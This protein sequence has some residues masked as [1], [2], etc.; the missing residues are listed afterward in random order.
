MIDLTRNLISREISNIFDN[1]HYKDI[2]ID[3]NIPTQKGKGNLTTN[4]A[5]VTFKDF[6]ESVKNNLLDDNL[7]NEID[8]IKTPFDYADWLANKIRV[9]LLDVEYN[10]TKI[11]KNIEAATPGFINFYFTDEFLI[12]KVNYLALN[13]L[14]LR[15]GESK[16]Y[17]VEYSSPNIAK[18]FTIGHFRTTI[19]GNSIANLLETTGN[20]VYRDNHLGDWGTQFG[21][22]IY[23]IKTWGNEDEIDKSERPVKDLVDLYIKFHDEVKENP[24][25]EDEGRKWFALLE[26]DDDEAKRLWK[27]CIDWSWKEFNE[28]YDKL[29]VHFTENNGRG[30]GESFF[31]PMVPDILEELEKN[32][33]ITESEGAKLVFFYDDDELPPLMIIKSDGSTLYSTRD[34][35]TDKFRLKKYGN[36]VTII[37]EVGGDQKL[38]FRQIFR[39]EEILGWYK[40]EQRLH[41]WHGLIRLKD[42][43]MSTRRGNVVWLEDVLNETFKRTKEISSDLPDKD[44]W[45]IAIGALK[46]NDFKRKRQVDITFDWNEILNIKGNSGPYM[47]YTYVRGLGILNNAK[48]HFNLSENDIK[49][50]EDVGLIELSEIEK[51]LIHKLINYKGVIKEATNDFD[52]TIIATYLYELAQMFNKFYVEQKIIDDNIDLEIVKFRLNII[53]SVN[54]VIKNGLEILGIKVVD[55]M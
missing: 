7:I 44:V 12:S 25:I 45:K 54:K 53:L 42:G 32:N 2:N 46:W 21:K 6:Q 37:N 15:L 19:I 40:P 28:I 22:L 43:K 29:D 23:A 5:L 27:K 18:P 13:K 36:D 39:I 47:Q 16:K 14:D 51:E 9:R 38:Y 4:V 33:L 1:L 50:I 11:F 3:V 35:A 20:E 41:I 31:V 55:K 52:L 30:Y 49:K 48:S 34:L 24:D 10:S 17:V 26:S 8:Y